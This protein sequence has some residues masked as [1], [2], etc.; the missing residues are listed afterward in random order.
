MLMTTEGHEIKTRGADKIALLGLFVLSILIAYG[1]VSIRSAV[2]FEYPIKLMDTGLSVS[3][4]SGDGWQSR[5]R[6]L[7]EGDSFSLNSAFTADQSSPEVVLRFRYLLVVSDASSGEHFEQKLL[8]FGGELV[9]TGQIET[10]SFHINW[11]KVLQRG[12][13]SGI[14]F[15][16]VMLPD[17]HHLDVEVHYLSGDDD[18]AEQVF[19]GAVESIKFEGDEIY[20]KHLVKDICYVGSL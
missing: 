20:T 2:V 9:E 15:G 16:T 3:I 1:I 12:G 6:W 13:T 17:S 7:F 4:P 10:S 11:G 19:K 14:Y 8:V 5:Q 18:F